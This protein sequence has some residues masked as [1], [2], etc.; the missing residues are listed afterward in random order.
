MEM[1][2]TSP[3]R[4]S[5]W[6][7][8]TP[9]LI[10]STVKCDGPRSCADSAAAKTNPKTG[11][12]RVGRAFRI[13]VCNLRFITVCSIDN[14]GLLGSDNFHGL[15]GSPDYDNLVGYNR[16]RYDGWR[17]RPHFGTDAWTRLRLVPPE[18][19]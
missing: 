9:S 13:R 19:I 11:S 2:E 1:R 3:G 7:L 10:S 14:S 6:L 18:T 5:T 15:L 4:S 17:H 8:P 16:R 12:H